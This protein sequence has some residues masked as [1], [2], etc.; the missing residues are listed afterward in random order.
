MEVTLAELNA[1]LN[2][3]NDSED[4]Q[5]QK[6]GMLKSAQSI[7]E[8]NLG[9]TLGEASEEET[10]TWVNKCSF[11]IMLPKPVEITTLKINGDTITDYLCHGIWYVKDKDNMYRDYKNAEIA[12][13][14]YWN[15]QPTPDIVK[16]VMLKIASL[17]FMETQKRIGVSGVQLPDGMG[18]QYISYTNYDKHLLALTPYRAPWRFSI[19]KT[20]GAVAEAITFDSATQ[21]GG[22]PGL[23]STTEILL[24]FDKNPQTLLASDITITGAT[25][26]TLSGTGNIR[27]ISI[28]NI[29]VADGETVTVAI[30]SPDGYTLTGSPKDV[31]VYVG[32]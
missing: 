30:A 19:G 9:Y 8:K 29:T 10:Y 31:V 5:A 3:Y 6:I 15:L 27:T 21:V 14:G 25:K 22:V 11:G 28:T 23:T 12:I 4:I 16:L 24:R 2:D 13:T 20:I 7:V 18:H 1:Y 17:M 26:G 32:A